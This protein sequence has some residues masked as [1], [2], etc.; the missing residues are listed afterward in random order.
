MIIWVYEQK[1]DWILEM[2]KPFLEVY[3]THPFYCPYVYVQWTISKGSTQIGFH[4]HPTHASLAGCN[5]GG[6]GGNL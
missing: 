5:N 4:N 3:C 6:G 2:Q 1:P